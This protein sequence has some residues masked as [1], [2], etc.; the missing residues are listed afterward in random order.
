MEE[1]HQGDPG[2]T[3]KA[4][5]AELKGAEQDIAKLGALQGVLATCLGLLAAATIAATQ[6]PAGAAQRAAAR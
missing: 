5:G 2:L 6:Q 3:I 4:F 1:Q